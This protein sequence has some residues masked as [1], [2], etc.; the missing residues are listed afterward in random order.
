MRLLSEEAARTVDGPITAASHQ[1]L[2]F[3]DEYLQN[4]YPFLATLRQSE[5]VFFS[6]ELGAWIVTRHET[7]K[8]VLR[9]SARFSAII[10]SDPLTPMCPMAR[11]IVQNSEFDVPPMLVNNDP[12][13]H[14]RYRKF[15]GQPLNRPRLLKLEPFIRDTVGEYLDRLELSKRP[16]DLIQGL[17]WDVPALVLFELMG[18]PKQDVSKVKAWADSRVVLTWGRPTEAEQIRLAQGAVEYYRY[19][20]QLVQSKAAN[21]TDDYLSDLIRLRNNDDSMMS[22]REITGTAFNLLFAGHETTSGASASLFLTLLRNRSLWEAVCRGDVNPSAVVEEGLRFESPVHAWRRQAKED[23]ELD[24][25]KVPA[26]SRLQ[27]VIGAANRDDSVFADADTF[28]PARKDVQNHVAFGS[29]LHL[30]LGAPLARLEIQIMLEL[31]SQR[32]P[33]LQ[34]VENQELEYVPNTAMRALRRLMVTW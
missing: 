17:T 29:G 24:G 31:L 16:A 26:G 8:Q 30:C 18:V 22:M 2:P 10:V 4:P 23:V 13:S 1:Y 7:V 14:T 12:P 3:S 28:N 21:P 5:P 33:N 6:P 15:F 19:A 9:D 25:V 32:F 20:A 34:L 27:L 11:S